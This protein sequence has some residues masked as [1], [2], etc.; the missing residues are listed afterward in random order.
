MQIL[1]GKQLFIKKIISC[2]VK[3]T[4]NSKVLVTLISLSY[5]VVNVVH[6]YKENNFKAVLITLHFVYIN[7]AKIAAQRLI[8]ATIKR[9]NKK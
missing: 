6:N 9:S 5:K 8:M 1:L 2:T 3:T 4:S 7:S